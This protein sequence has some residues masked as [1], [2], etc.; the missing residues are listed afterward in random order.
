MDKFISVKI[1]F[2]TKSKGKTT[3]NIKVLAG[4]NEILQ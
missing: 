2:E 1:K 4:K 3:T